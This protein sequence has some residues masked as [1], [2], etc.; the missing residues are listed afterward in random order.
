[1]PA[2]RWTALNM[3]II[4]PNGK[5]SWKRGCGSAQLVLSFSIR[6]VRLR[7]EPVTDKSVDYR[8]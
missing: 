5:V 4:C 3:K 2:L 7:N 6:R 1:M 8:P